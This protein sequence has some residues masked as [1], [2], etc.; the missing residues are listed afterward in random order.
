MWDGDKPAT[1]IQEAARVARYRLLAG[2]CGRSGCL[3]LLTAHH[4]EDQAETYL[5]R[6]RAG[7]GVDGLAGM[8]AVRELPG[9]AGAAAARGAQSA[10]RG[11]PDGE[12]QEYVGDPSNRNPAFEASPAAR[13]RRYQRSLRRGRR[14]ACRGR[15]DR[16]RACARRRCWRGGEPAPG[17]LCPDRPDAIVA[18]GELA[19]TAARAGG[20]LHRRRAAYPL[21]RE[22]LARLR[23]ALPPRRERAR[24][25]GGC[26]FVPWRG[27]V[28]GVARNLR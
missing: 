5:I 10:A 25:L 28:L 14:K 11:A 19:Q 23:A 3:H 4:R 2:W 24:T 15:P 1:G 9:A 16:A 27:R 18:A 22:R 20:R 8:S 13:R 21:R 26:R 12:G 6:R 7:S 17:G